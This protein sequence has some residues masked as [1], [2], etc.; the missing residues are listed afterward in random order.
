[1][2]ST[3][4]PSTILVMFALPLTA[5]ADPEF[6]TPDITDYEYAEAI[7]VS[8]TVSATSVAGV[9]GFWTDLVDTE[10][11][12]ADGAGVY[13]AVLDTGL[14][15]A[16]PFFFSQADIAT[17][18][19]I[20]FSHDMWWDDDAGLVIGPL[21]DDRGF[22]TDL[23]SAHGTHV[24][25]TVVG[26]NVNN[27]FWV[28]GVAPQATIIPVLVLDAWEVEYPGGTLQLSGGTDAMVAAGIYYVGD[29]APTLDGPVV[30]NMS[31]G[32]PDRSPMIEAA[33]DYAVSQGVIVV[34]SA[35]NE[36]MDGMGYPGGLEQIISA[37]AAGWATM[38][39]NG[40][41]GDV[42]EN[43][44]SGDLLGNNRQIYLEDFSSR[45]N[46]DLDQKHQ[47]LD[48]SAPG[49]WVVGPYKPD[50]SNDLGYYY[51]SGTS[52]ASPHVAGM[53]ALVL[54]EHPETG[55][56]DMEFLL[57][58]AAA[59]QSLPACD[60][61]VLFPFIPEGFYTATWDG[62]DYG[63]GFLQADAALQFADELMQ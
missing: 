15:S 43:L 1:M 19:G 7:T 11:V 27:Q 2:K 38:F 53:A 32:G 57:E 46:M 45:P 10:N 8:E 61:V 51:V 3:L 34:A 40:W 58:R 44:K 52:M 36:G 49:A 33:V 48:V 62:G 28:S 42:P 4:I 56:A 54:E 39:A 13:V 20:G 59:G 16:W 18:L 21:R 9:P 41:L 50:F 5:A 29:L 47:D 35:G 63:K 14:H 23:A 25:S 30:I 60:A 22:I 24:S 37:G 26:F 55:Q 31:L 12:A 17:E 6:F